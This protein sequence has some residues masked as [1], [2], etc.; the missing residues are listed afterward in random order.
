MRRDSCAMWRAGGIYWSDSPTADALSQP[1][2]AVPSLGKGGGGGVRG[3][4]KCLLRIHLIVI[5][6]TAFLRCRRPGVAVLGTLQRAVS[7]RV[8]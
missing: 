8:A 3:E 6:G 1:G 4:I 5:R 2:G 7:K